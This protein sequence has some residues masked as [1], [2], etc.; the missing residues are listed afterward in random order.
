M[1]FRCQNKISNDG[2]ADGHS[3]KHYIASV[4]QMF[5]RFMYGGV[6]I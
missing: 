5:A 4:L 6:I 3:S 1:I 2:V